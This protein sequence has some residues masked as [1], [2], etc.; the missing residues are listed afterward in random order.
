M[1]P[2]YADL[3]VEASSGDLRED[4]YR[5]WS[6]TGVP[7]SG[8]LHEGRR[9]STPSGGAIRIDSQAAEYGGYLHDISAVY[10]NHVRVPVSRSLGIEVLPEEE[11]FP[12]I[13]HQKLS[14]QMARSVPRLRTRHI[15]CRR[16]PYD[17]PQAGHDDRQGAVRCR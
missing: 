13:V 11:A 7:D 9:R 1:N 16:L 4:V 17:A 5:F 8:A 2:V 14:R 3:K 15:G 6:G 10:P 12:M